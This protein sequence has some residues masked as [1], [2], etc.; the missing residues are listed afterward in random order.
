MDQKFET[1]PL[2]ILKKCAEEIEVTEM[3]ESTIKILADKPWFQP[4]HTNFQHFLDK[5][6]P[7]TY[8]VSM[9]DLDSMEVLSRMN[10]IFSPI[11]GNKV[12]MNRMTTSACHQNS[13][14]LHIKNPNLTMYYG[15]AL[16]DDARW[17]NHSWL[18]DEENNI[19]ETT[20]SRLIYIGLAEY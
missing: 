9:P 15:W 13:E 12:I 6:V 8:I 1:I 5:N 4:T 2:D 16:S 10:E 17:R 20:E 11:C 18:I 19:I 7:G 14:E 3:S